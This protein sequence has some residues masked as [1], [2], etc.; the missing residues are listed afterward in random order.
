MLAI[1][2]S[3]CS[4]RQIIKTELEILYSDNYIPLSDSLTASGDRIFI[5]D[6]ER[7]I[8]IDMLLMQSIH[9]HNKCENKLEKIR[10]INSKYQPWIY[11]Q[12]IFHK[13]YT[14]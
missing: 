13:T 6:K 14:P 7:N 4:K 8:D 12:S 1:I 3:G 5:N 10:K 2:L 9:Y 11:N